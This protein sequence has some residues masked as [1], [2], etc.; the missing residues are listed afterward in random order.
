MIDV[1]DFAAIPAIDDAVHL[2]MKRSRGN[3]LAAR[4]AVRR[5]LKRLRSA[6]AQGKRPELGRHRGEQV[7]GDD[8]TNFP[9]IRE[10]VWLYFRFILSFRD[11]EELMVARERG[12]L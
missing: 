2:L 6:A 11:V 8:E 10:A 1:R 4:G 7:V 9:V 12:Q 5:T 3:S